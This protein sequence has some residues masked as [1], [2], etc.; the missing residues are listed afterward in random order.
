M[1]TQTNENIA[2]YFND[3]SPESQYYQVLFKPAV[4]VQ[5]RELNFL[6][7]M[8][9]NQIEQFGSN[10]MQS[11]TI[12][13]GC[14]FNFLE[15]YPFVKLN[16]VS[17]D[18]FTVVPSSLVGYFAVGGTTGVR[19]AI[20][21]SSD[22]FQATDP[23]LKTLYLK[24]LNAG[25][26]GNT[27]TFAAGEV[28]TVTDQFNGLFGFNIIGSGINFSNSD[29]AVIIPQMAVNVTSGTFTNGT[30]IINPTTGA[31]LQI[32]NIDTTTLASINQ[33]LITFA[34]RSVD[35]ANVFSNSTNWT[36]S[37]GISIRDTSSTMA[38]TIQQI[39][40]SS[41]TGT[42]QTDGSGRVIQITPTNSG[43]GYIYVPYTTIR[44]VNNTTGYSS[45]SIQ[46]QNYVANPTVAS[47][48]TPTGNG[49]AFAINQGWIFQNG[50]FLRVNPQTIIVSKYDQ[51]PNAIGVAF[52][53]QE[54]VV[55]SDSDPSLLDNAIGANNYTAPGADRLKL[56]PTLSLVTLSAINTSNTY[57]P[58]VE[59]SEGQPFL[60]LP[61][62]QYSTIDKAMAM[63]TYDEAGNFVLAPFNIN[64]RTTQNTSSSANLF[65]IVV[66]PGTAYIDGEKVQ[67]VRD[68][69]VDC[70]KGLDSVITNNYLLSLNYGN[71][72]RVRNVAGLF[73]YSTGD[74]VQ[75]YDTPV[76]Y[77]TNA[78]AIASGTITQPG[79]LIANARVRSMILESG[80][81]A[82]NNAVYRLYLFN[83]IVA[84]GKNIS[85]AQS[86][87]YNNTY[88][89]IADIILESSGTNT[90]NVCIVHQPNLSCLVFST[91]ADATIKNS[92]NTSYT[93]RTIDQTTS[94]S[95]NGILTKSLS[96]STTD[97][98]P[99]AV[100]NLQTL[101]LESLYVVPLSNNI[102][103]FASI[104]GTLNLTATSPTVTGTSTGF[105][106]N[107]VAG[108]W[109][110]LTSNSTGGNTLAQ[111]LSITNNTS[112]TLTAN[113]G[114]TNSVGVAYRTFPKFLAVPFGTRTGLSANV[115]AN[116]QILTLNFGFN[117]NGAVGITTAL[118]VNI[119]RNNTA[120]VNKSIVRAAYVKINMANSSG[121][122]VG[123]WCLGVPDIA[124]LTGVWQGNSSVDATGPNLITNFTIDINQTTDWL[125]LG[126]LTINPKAGITLSNTNYL[127]VRFDYFTT[128][129]TGYYTPQSYVS[130][131]LATQLAV[132]ALPYANLG[133]QINTWEI[134]NFQDNYGNWYDLLNSFDFRPI[135]A[136]T[137]T[138]G[139]IPS[140]APVNPSSTLSFGN[141]ASTLNDKH[142][143]LPGSTMVTTLEQFAGRN[144]SLYLTD[145]ARLYLIKGTPSVDPG[146]RGL[147]DPRPSAIK[148]GDIAIPDYP[149]VSNNVSLN[150][151]YIYTTFTTSVAS[152]TDLAR[153]PNQIITLSPSTSTPPGYTM[154]RIK[155]LD[156]RISALEYYT[157]L[158][159]LESDLT[160]RVVPSSLSNTI[161]RFKFGIYVDDYANGMVSD[162]Y[163]PEYHA[164]IDNMHAYPLRIQ[165]TIPGPPPANNPGPVTPPQQPI[166]WICQNTATGV[167]NTD[168]I[169]EV[170]NFTSNTDF[171]FVDQHAGFVSGSWGKDNPDTFQITATSAVS[172]N[173][174]V[175]FFSSAVDPIKVLVY[176]SQQPIQSGGTLTLIA[177]SDNA[178]NLDNISDAAVFAADYDLSVWFSDQFTF[179]ISVSNNLSYVNPPTSSIGQFCTGAGKITFQHNPSLGSNYLFKVY[180]GLGAKNYKGAIIYPF[181]TGSVA[182]PS[183]AIPLPNTPGPNTPGPPPP[184]PP[185]TGP[186]YVGTASVYIDVFIANLGYSRS[187]SFTTPG[188]PGLNYY[189][190]MQVYTSSA[191]EAQIELGI[192]QL[193]APG[194]NSPGRSNIPFVTATQIQ[195][196]YNENGLSN[197][198]AG[199]GAKPVGITDVGYIA[200]AGGFDTEPNNV[201]DLVYI[202]FAGLM[203]STTH[204]IYW[205][206]DKW[207]TATTGIDGKL[208]LELSWTPS[209]GNEPQSITAKF[210]DQSIATAYTV[211]YSS[212]TP[213][214]LGEN[215]VGQGQ[216]VNGRYTISQTGAAD[217]V[218]PPP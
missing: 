87:F 86:V 19:A 185:P 109:V 201:F 153:L 198:L 125:D 40:G 67:T 107:L 104:G 54:I 137:C 162:L 16:D 13:S 26:S 179:P 3:Y 6:Q 217:W 187:T 105:T 41:A 138:P 94:V 218:A 119:K 175:Y 65:S 9:Q 211:N 28:L 39:F 11:G 176:R 169:I 45:L 215:G 60:Q 161:N 110:F 72:I 184:P 146:K 139:N 33:L 98:Y 118:G 159:S 131:N 48:V 56:I 46:A 83:T 172:A 43:N 70:N 88:Q 203:P 152:S 69:S 216:D 7:S 76:S 42:V 168:C 51:N 194:N 32:V 193:R 44:S 123:P 81:P 205:N 79:N 8:L 10:I 177:S 93:Y 58:L 171:F 114:I 142:F 82:T 97:F 74:T 111:V 103:S 189:S 115:D 23:N 183:P 31:N 197:S 199:I 141:T 35:L 15:S 22:G 17:V 50:Y 89:G 192:W 160:Q 106:S 29:F 151:Q 173:V 12:L 59:W 113:A 95:N 71:Y 68:F 140:A 36:F 135:A 155:T 200:G 134:P 181:F 178:A 165:W 208:Y 213:D 130:S 206:Q 38:G 61:N 52:Q 24:Y 53:T 182:C 207:G 143:P 128:S 167:A 204:D 149:S 62:T 127:L 195:N 209:Y 190:G 148:L 210:Q 37:N 102:V 75:L 180:K 25:T 1:T 66:S 116:Q 2:P 154:A 30:Y 117:T 4:S 21:N 136:N 158:N 91:G 214:I 166:C 170:N 163:N 84:N 122:N 120:P 96:T 57:L 132:D 202:N 145:N 20:I 156:D 18:G 14:N 124:R 80:T 73:Q 191:S 85:A 64:T 188:Q 101:D 157:S 112:M 164:T 121:N 129:G 90:A 147:A 49:Y 126:W 34:P 47:V 133:A 92:N 77:V 144:D 55:T 100:G 186:K 196:Q 63:R 108:D 99:F 27:T 150:Q 212:L 78:A 174:S 5:A